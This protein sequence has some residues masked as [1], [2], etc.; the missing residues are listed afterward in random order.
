MAFICCYG[1]YVIVIDLDLLLPSKGGPGGR[2]FAGC[3]HPISGMGTPGDLHPT[4][5]M[6]D[7]ETIANNLRAK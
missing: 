3:I 7:P 2:K 5:T 4:Q 1:L 6:P